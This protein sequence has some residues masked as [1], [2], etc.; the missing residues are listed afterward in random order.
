ML[1][2]TAPEA[3]ASAN[4]VWRNIKYEPERGTKALAN[5]T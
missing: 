2:H 5:K 1:S 4:K 3:A